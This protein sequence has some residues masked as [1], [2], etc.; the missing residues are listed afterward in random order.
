MTLPNTSIR[1]I[2]T[3]PDEDLSL[4]YFD[5]TT[6]ATP[7][8]DNMDEN[9]IL[10]RT[11]YLSCDPYQKGR[12]SAVFKGLPF[13]INPGETMDGIGIGVVEASTSPDF[14]V[15]D[16]VSGVRVLW[17]TRFISKTE[18]FTK[19]PVD[20]KIRPVDHLGVLSMASF[21]GY[22]GLVVVGKP[23]EGETLLVSSAAGGV[24]QM[25]VQLAKAR[26]MRV[27]ATAGSDDKVEFVKSLGADAVFNYKTCGD[28]TDAIK[29]YAPGGI[30]LYYDNVGGKFLDA[31]I[32]NMKE[33]GRIVLCGM[34][35]QYNLSREDRYG[36]KNMYDAI[37]RRISFYGYN[38]SDHYAKSEYQNF[39]SEVSDLYRENK[40]K[41]KLFE[42]KGLENAPQALLDL[43]DSK[44][45]GKP[46]VNVSGDSDF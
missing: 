36:I 24:G 11:L 6:V 25:V 31:T 29:R 34:S 40:I 15:G 7:S 12:V 46:I 21:T 22:V 33:F 8:A 42:I 19:V 18:G 17:Q 39:I 10:I 27:I 43:L 2:K 37:V 32:M 14:Q 30:D 16:V 9:S 13:A 38:V 1:L 41:Y 28:Y 5:I 35:S 20:S 45:Y 23:K 3:A 26:G 4:S 44:M